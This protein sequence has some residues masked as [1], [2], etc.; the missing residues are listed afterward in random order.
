MGTLTNIDRMPAPH[1]GW[2][3]R[4]RRNGAMVMRYFGDQDYGG[5]AK[6][7]DAAR[8]LRDSIRLNSRDGRLRGRE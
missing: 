7:L 6:S 5:K 2:R 4:I 1:R 3:L 8:T